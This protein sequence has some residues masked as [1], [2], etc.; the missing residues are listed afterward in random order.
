M[1]QMTMYMR[2]LKSSKHIISGL[3][4]LYVVLSPTDP[5]M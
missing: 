4:F 1:S 3:T 5:I 2:D